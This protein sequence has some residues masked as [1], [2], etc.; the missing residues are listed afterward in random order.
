MKL[1][2][3]FIFFI[4]LFLLSTTLHAQKDSIAVDSTRITNW[5]LRVGI[6]LIPSVQGWI[7]GDNSS[8]EA[9]VDYR[10]KKSIYLAAEF[11]IENHYQTEDFF[12]YQTNGG[13][14]KIGANYNAY[15]NWLD[16]NNEIYVGGRFAYSNFTQQVNRITDYNPGNY[17]P[18]YTYYPDQGKSDPLNAYWLEFVAGLKVETFKNVFLGMQVSFSKIVSETEPEGFENLYVPGIGRTAVN[19]IGTYFSYTISY[20]IPFQKK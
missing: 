17:F 9:V 16:M 13:F 10:I 18:A 20:L 12:D 3:H 15:K 7:D 6:N 5:G 11:G 1:R 19:N 8:Y 2:R 14:V 4:S